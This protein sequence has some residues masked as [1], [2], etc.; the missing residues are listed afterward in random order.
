MGAGD[1]RLR[2]RREVAP[3]DDIGG[4]CPQGDV[5]VQVHV[6]EAHG[7][8]GICRVP[9]HGSIGIDGQLVGSTLTGG[10]GW[11]VH[12]VE[13]IFLLHR[14]RKKLGVVPIVAF[15]D[16]SNCSDGGSDHVG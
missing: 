1:V 6:A 2:A 13:R 10:E 7:L 3:I 12:S 5:A 4:V 8:I 11:D 14:E 15:L 9:I 16:V